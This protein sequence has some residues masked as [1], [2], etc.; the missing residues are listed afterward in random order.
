MYI[1]LK[2]IIATTCFICLSK[3]STAQIKLIENA[4]DKSAGNVECYKIITPIATYFLEKN[5][6]GLSSLTDKDGIDWI[7]FNSEAGSGAAGEYRGFPN[8]VHQQDGNF[9]HPKNVNTDSSVSRVEYRSTNHVKIIGSSGN[10]AWECVWDFYPTFCQFTMSR[11]PEKHQ[12]WVLYEGT[13]GGECDEND[14]YYTSAIKEKTPITQRHESDIPSPEWIAFGD[15]TISRSLFMVH[16]QDDSEIDQLY[17]MDNK[18]VVFGFGRKGIEK[19]LVSV[20]RKFSIGFVESDNY[21]VIERKVLEFVM[22][23][24]KK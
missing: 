18:M 5:G 24:N 19:S 16:H 20:P 6:L 12:Y 22:N 11:M 3:N 9:F 8:A 4:I 2:L 17:Q 13:P 10:K 23:N 15:H 1:F 21:Q 14:W 7:G